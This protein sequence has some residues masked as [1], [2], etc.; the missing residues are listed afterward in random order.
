[1]TITAAAGS[2]RSGN[3]PR[4]GVTAPPDPAAIT[5]DAQELQEYRSTV[6]R[7]AETRSDAVFTNGRPEH[8]AII[9]E[10]FLKHAKKRVVMFCKNLSNKVF[11]LPG[12]V[13]RFEAAHLKGIKIAV[14]TQEDPECKELAAKLRVWESED[15]KKCTFKPNSPFSGV[16]ANFAVMDGVA[17]R[18]EPN[19][20][21]I[22]AHACMFN[23]RMASMLEDTFFRFEAALT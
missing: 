19:K 18:F 4:V 22:A 13:E 21:D 16:D 11:G 6:E 5:L 23:P 15:P 1:M 10:A 2:P 7:L 20:G 3:T 14:I 9:F 12:M 17:Y 8:A